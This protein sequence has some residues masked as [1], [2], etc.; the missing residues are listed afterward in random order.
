MIPEHKPH[1]SN[2]FQQT[3]YPFKLGQQDLP[4]L[5]PIQ[6][7]LYDDP[8]INIGGPKSLHIN[9]NKSLVLG[10]H[11]RHTVHPYL[12]E[13]ALTRIG[14]YKLEINPIQ[15]HTGHN[16]FTSGS[17]PIVVGGSLWLWCCVAKT[18]KDERFRTAA[19]QSKL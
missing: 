16:L 7:I 4:S 15:L 2:D 1:C 10:L 12:S 8:R 14:Y 9:A 11:S 13:A 17:W 19:L 3:F 18:S 5:D 6:I